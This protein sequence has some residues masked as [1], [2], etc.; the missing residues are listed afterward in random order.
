MNRKFQDIQGKK[1]QMQI[2]SSSFLYS[3]SCS[4][5]PG[6]YKGYASRVSSVSFKSM[7][8]VLKQWKCTIFVPKHCFN[9]GLQTVITI[10]DHNPTHVSRIICPYVKRDKLYVP[11]CI[12]SKKKYTFC[13]S[14]RSR[15]MTKAIDSDRRIWVPGSAY[16]EKPVFSD[17]LQLLQ[18]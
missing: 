4:L 14:S 10:S 13:T 9:P 6:R 17:S 16:T 15:L 8:V 3:Q 1:E 2:N 7:N 18:F 12:T 5:R 11:L